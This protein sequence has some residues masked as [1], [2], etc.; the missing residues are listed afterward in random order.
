MGITNL[1]H[2]VFYTRS[3]KRSAEF[4]SRVL[5]FVVVIEDPDDTYVFMRGPDSSNHHDLVFFSIDDR[6]GPPTAGSTSAGVY[7]VGWEV[8]TLDDLKAA[9]RR[10]GEAGA[11][12][13]ESDHVANKSLYGKD[14]D[15]LE[16]EVMWLA[17]VEHWGEAVDTAI[18]Q[19]LDIDAE[20]D[21]FAALAPHHR[22]P[23]Q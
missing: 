18:I 23:T 17:P 19:P 1:N 3:A 7:H 11:L 22:P 13:G 15:G 14:P 9:R 16:F 10:L 4:Y 12:V 5:D 20:I 21:R 2:V 6:A 8:P